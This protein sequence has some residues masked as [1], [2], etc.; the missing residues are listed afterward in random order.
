MEMTVVAEGLR[1][2]E[3]PIAMPDGTVLLVEIA[4]RTLSRVH[5]DGRVEVVAETGGGPNGAA[6]GPDGRVWICNNGGFAWTQRNGRD[7]PGP[8]PE[9]YTG[10][11]IQAVDLATGA[12][13]T[14]YT[15]CGEF[16]LRGP[17]DLVFDDAG[18]FWFTD[19]GKAR[20]RDR[21]VGGLY[22]AKA[23]GSS[24]E[25]RSWGLETPNGVGL[26]P[27]GTMLSV[28]MTTTGRVYQWR[29][30]EPG[31]FDS[32]YAN[33]RGTML[34][35]D[36][37]ENA[38]ESLA[39]D[40]EGHVCVATI[41]D[42]GITDIAPDGTWTH[43]PTGDRLTTNICFGGEDLRTAFITCSASGTLVRCR[44]PRPGLRLHH[45]PY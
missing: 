19:P 42:G 14:I 23:D 16:G 40:G 13:E 22:Y 36:P 17:N 45:N 12:V 8:Q 18:G 11:S 20:A 1:F 29:L 10:G 30:A 44:W 34:M 7:I 27:D 32:P 31:R 3:G 21:D 15:H 25:Q 35:A 9:D 28:A 37:G 6:F 43:V 39:V 26:S 41:R 38:F 2:P 4:R 33:D 5:P 24:I